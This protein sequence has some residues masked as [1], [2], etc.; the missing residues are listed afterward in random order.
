MGNPVGVPAGPGGGG[1]ATLPRSA[2]TDSLALL[3]PSRRPPPPPPL[4]LPNGGVPEPPQDPPSIEE[5]LQIIHSSERLLPDGAPDAFYLH[6]PDP[7]GDPRDPSPARKPP[8]KDPPP[9]SS[10]SSSS[11]TMTSFAERKKKLE[12]AAG[13]KSGTSSG[14]SATLP[15]AGGS[16]QEAGGGL[17]AEMSALGARLEEKRRAIEAQK[18]R[19]E[20]I[21][22]K[23]RQRLGH[24]ALRKLARD[25]REEEEEED[26]GSGVKEE[27]VKEGTKPPG[28]S[29]GQYEAAVARLSA[30]LSSLQLD[31]QRLTRQQ[32]RLLLEQRPPT[33]NTTPAA[34]QAWVIPLPKPAKAAAGTPQKAPGSPAA[35]RKATATT[36]GGGGGSS[37]VA[38]GGSGGVRKTPQAPPPR[39]PRRPRP[40]ELR[41]PPLTRVL[42]PP[43]DVDTLPHLRR[44][45]PSQVPVQTRSSLRLSHGEEEEEE[46][47][48]VEEEE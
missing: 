42:T 25:G 6:S 44:F 41:L 32:E 46:E 43:Q 26:E 11:R 16:P 1:P 13:D 23:H 30:A 48:E 34:P 37:G 39:S 7:P 18:K 38:S 15:Q 22:A 35:A 20:A 3:G 17:S 33:Q 21:F 5:A 29:P 8:Q 2:S 24:S 9:S 31:M 36:G 4:P 47:E 27:G 10:S 12:E 28:P 14:C 45:S 19:I 40:A